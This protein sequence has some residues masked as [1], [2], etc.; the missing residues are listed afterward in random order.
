MTTTTAITTPLSPS[1]EQKL[2]LAQEVN[3][4]K[5]Y[6]YTGGRAPRHVTHVF[7]HPSIKIIP[8]RAFYC[9]EDLIYVEIH[10]GINAI[11]KEAFKKCISLRHIIITGVVRIAEGAFSCCCALMAVEGSERLAKIGVQAFLDCNSLG[12]I[13]LPSV[14]IIKASAF[15]GCTNIRDGN[16]GP[17]LK[18]IEGS[19]F[20][21]CISLRQLRFELSDNDIS[22]QRDAFECCHRLVSIEAVGNVRKD[23]TSLGS[24]QWQD[25]MNQEIDRIN[26]LLPNIHS[27]QKTTEISQWIIS[28][29]RKMKCYKMMETSSL[30]ELALWKA[31][32]LNI[33]EDS[34]GLE[35]QWCRVYCGAEIVIPNVL[36]FM[37]T[38]K[39]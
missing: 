14:T 26:H 13:N 27:S 38:M 34:S 1:W 5:I 9:C 8:F 25:D 19:A 20:Y 31:A 29:R 23:I 37:T 22:I 32:K 12:Q 39:L 15:A 30:L 17:Y 24:E 7:I 21:Y 28:V 10:D 18:T 2:K 35:R 16:L 36:S 33:N 3:G 4:E 6:I 11:G